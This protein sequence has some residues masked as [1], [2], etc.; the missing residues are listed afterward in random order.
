[1]A[2]RLRISPASSTALPTTVSV[3][4]GAVSL[5]TLKFCRSISTSAV[6]P[7]SMFRS[8]MKSSGVVDERQYSSSGFCLARAHGKYMQLLAAVIDCRDTNNRGAATRRTRMKKIAAAAAVSALLAACATTPP[9]LTDY[10]VN[11]GALRPIDQLALEFDKADLKLRIEPASHSIVGDATLTFGTRVR[12]A[13]IDLD[14]DRN[15]P[16]DAIEVDGQ[17]LPASNWR[18]PDGRL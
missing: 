16:I 10:T 14:L 15:L 6:R 18:N 7:I 8:S 17:P 5:F 13:R 12:L 1:M 4:C 11:S 2:P 3:L 9:P